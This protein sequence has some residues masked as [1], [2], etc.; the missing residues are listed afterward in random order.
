MRTYATFS[1]LA[2]ASGTAMAAPASP[3]ISRDVAFS[4][5]PNSPDLSKG[6]DMAAFPSVTP[7]GDTEELSED[8]LA[9]VIG[10]SKT[11]NSGQQPSLS[12]RS[13]IPYR[14]YEKWLEQQ[15]REYQTSCAEMLLPCSS[16]ADIRYQQKLNSA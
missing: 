11:D 9:G 14:E 4:S 15:R 3:D 10:N 2:L 13:A 7:A 5:L 6:S 12:A 8:P 16:K 1:L